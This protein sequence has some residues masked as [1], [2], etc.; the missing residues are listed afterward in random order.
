MASLDLSQFGP[1]ALSA[2]TMKLFQ[3]LSQS[4]EFQAMLGQ[5]AQAGQQFGSNLT[6]GLSQRGLQTSGIGT[7]ANA[8][9]QSATSAGESA[10]RGGLFGQSMD[11]ALKLLLS[12]L[13]AYS[14][15]KTAQANQPSLFS[16]IFGGITGAAATALPFLS[17]PGKAIGAGIEAVA[18]DKG[19]IS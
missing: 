18:G 19:R 9:G 2:D 13:S 17:G 4:P 7:I 5:N 6:A 11:S 15:F 10:L 1:G 12:R 3:F 14:Q 8:A 16:Q